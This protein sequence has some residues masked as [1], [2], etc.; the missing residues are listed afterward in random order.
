MTYPSFS[1][2]E[3]LGAQDMNAV[4]LWLV[5]TQTV[6]T[7]VPS[8]TV[9]DAFSSEYSNYRITW[10]GG[11]KSAN[12]AVALK[13]GTTAVNTHF[14]SFIYADFTG[15][16]V[17]SVPDNNSAFFSN[18]GGANSDGGGAIIDVYGPN[19]PVNT[20][21]AAFGIHYGT[22]FGTYAGLFNATTQFTSFVLAPATGTMTGGTVRV[23]GYRD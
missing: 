4:G 12:D 10:T 15:V 21:I 14:G 2:G 23:Y 8:I 18:V 6:G 16:G 5:K 11:T 17:T 7:G 20:R 22:R 19:L 9:T 13:L 3:V 1:A